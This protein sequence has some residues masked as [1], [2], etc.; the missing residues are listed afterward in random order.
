MKGEHFSGAM[1]GVGELEGTRGVSGEANF[2]G[3]EPG[4]ELAFASGVAAQ[5]F[6][7]VEDD[8]ARL[9]VADLVVD[10]CDFDLMAT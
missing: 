3:F 9:E 2:P 1:F 5:G 8:A 6:D 4:G 10:T 7:E